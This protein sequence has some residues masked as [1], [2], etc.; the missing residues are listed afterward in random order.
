[1]LHT[2]STPELL[3]DS[4]SISLGLTAVSYRQTPGPASGMVNGT[5]WSAPMMA[6]PC[7]FTWMASRL[8]QALRHQEV[9]T[10]SLGTTNDLYI[11]TYHGSCNLSFVGDIDA[12]KIWSRSLSPCEIALRSTG[13]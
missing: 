11:G 1:M 12:V 13:I 7:G 6:V 10:Y 9:S 2:R 5:M 8:G 3:A 4:T